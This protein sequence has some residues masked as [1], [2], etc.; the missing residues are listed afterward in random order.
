MEIIDSGF[1]KRSC[2]GVLPS[3]GV[4]SAVEFL[5]LPHCVLHRVQLQIRAHRLQID[6]WKN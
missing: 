6:N 3:G 5:Q 4:E 2:I 1:I